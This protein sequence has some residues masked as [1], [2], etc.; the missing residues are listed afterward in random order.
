VEADPG[1]GVRFLCRLPPPEGVAA[2]PVEGIPVPQA[3]GDATWP[4]EL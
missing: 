4:S 2:A 1:G 3:W